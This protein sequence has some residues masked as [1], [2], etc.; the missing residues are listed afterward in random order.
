MPA[1]G[2]TMGWN[3][4]CMELLEDHSSLC[5]LRCLDRWICGH[6]NLEAGPSNCPTKDLKEEINLGSHVVRF[7]NG[8]FLPSTGLLPTL[9]V[10]GREGRLCGQVGNHEHSTDFESCRYVHH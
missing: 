1:P 5:T 7:R 9:M 10:P 4:S 6:S 8:R 3:R 2:T